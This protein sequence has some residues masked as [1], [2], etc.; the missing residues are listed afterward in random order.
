MSAIVAMFVAAF[1]SVM[2]RLAGQEF[3]EAVWIR[4]IL[5]AGEKLV[6]MTTNTLDDSLLIEIKKR[7]QKPQG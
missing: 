1:L 2:G 3:F 5:F 7:L 4:V 6:P